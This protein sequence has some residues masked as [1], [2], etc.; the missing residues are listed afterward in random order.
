MS[1]IKTFTKQG[2]PLYELDDQKEL[3]SG[4]EGKI[5]AIPK[6]KNLIAKIYHQGCVNINETKFSYLNKLDGNIFI[7]PKELLYSKVGGILGITMDYLSHDYYPLDALFNKNTCLKNAISFQIKEKISKQL[8]SAVKSAHDLKINIGDFSGLNIM[9]NNQ[10]DIKLIDV[11][12]YEIPGY[13]HSDK[14]L[15]EIR[16]WLKGGKVC[17]ESDYF[18]LSVVIFNYLTY[19]HPF[20]GVHKKYHQLEERMMRKIPVFKSDPDLIIPKCYEQITDNYLNEQF[21]KLYVLGERFLMSVDKL[22]QP[23]IGKK[24]L[25]QTFTE[26]DVLVQNVIS[27]VEIE[28]AFFTVNHGMLRTKDDYYIYDTSQKGIVFL[29]S[30]LKRSE[31]LDV[32]I[33]NHNIVLVDK[34]NEM[35]LYDKSYGKTEKITNIKLNPKSRYVHIENYVLMFNDDTMYK[36]NID[37]VKYKN[38]KFEVKEIF[39]QSFSTHSGII[40]NVGGIHYVH[41]FSGMDISVV[42]SPILTRGVFQIKDVGIIQYEENKQSKFKFYNIVNLKFNLFNEV[43]SFSHFAYRGTSQKDANLF[44]PKDNT[45]E[46]LRALDFYKIADIGC[47]TISTDTKLYNTN[48]GIIAVNETEAW[49]INKR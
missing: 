14:L 38:I 42:K 5:I 7:K 36:L 4:G 9:V 27:S 25:A 21:N 16:D 48:S 33:G 3:A 13:K 8:V 24:V 49:L 19:L 40:Q 44:V 12:S 26:K 10:G 29:K 22:A 30:V 46:V 6:N 17:T 39:G 35:H 41:Y 34:N 11:D 1:K 20:K 31:W 32:F 2:T 37:E 28:Y 23:V 18:A 43:D 15:R 45:I 47:S